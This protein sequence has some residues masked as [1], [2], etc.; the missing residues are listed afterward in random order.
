MVV[1][2]IIPNKFRVSQRA[3]PANI[4]GEIVISQTLNTF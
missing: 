4:P 1:I 2:E 3:P